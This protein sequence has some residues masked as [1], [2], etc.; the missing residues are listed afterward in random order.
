MILKILIAIMISFLGLSLIALSPKIG[1]FI[2]EFRKY[3]ENGVAK[4][5]KV[6]PNWLTI[7]WYGL[8]LRFGPSFDIWLIRSVGIGLIVIMAILFL[9]VFLPF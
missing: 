1:K 9:S 3:F 4:E 2:F 5:S 8:A 7:S 6:F